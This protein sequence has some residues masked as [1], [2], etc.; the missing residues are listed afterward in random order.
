MACPPQISW[1]GATAPSCPPPGYASGHI[2]QEPVLV[3]VY[4]NYTVFFVNAGIR[5]QL[6]SLH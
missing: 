5:T 1:G 3:L 2:Y 6:G 4:L